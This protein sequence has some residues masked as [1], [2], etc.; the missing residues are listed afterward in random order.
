MVAIHTSPLTTYSPDGDFL[1]TRSLARVAVPFFFMVTGQF[2]LGKV[3]QGRRP[4]S[5][6]WR[7]VKKI[8]L[9]YLVAVVLYLPVGL[10]AGHYQGLSP[11]SALRLLLFDGTF[12][13]LWYFPACATG[14]LLVYLLGRVLRGRGLLAVTGL[15]TRPASR[16][17]PTPATACL[18]P[19]CFS[20]WA[21]GWEAGHPPEGPLSTGWGFCSPWF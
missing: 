15:P 12:Y 8:L 3:L 19:P 7:Q 11:L 16:C 10:Y 9:L 6:L 4:F 5:A 17:S 1:L 2:V 14:L 21:P 18:W 13:H 20:S